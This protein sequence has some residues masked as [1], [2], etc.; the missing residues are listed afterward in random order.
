MYELDIAITIM[1]TLAWITLIPASFRIM[2]TTNEML[3]GSLSLALGMFAF[4]VSCVC[5]IGFYV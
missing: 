1:S 4:V 5:I 3:L 2:T